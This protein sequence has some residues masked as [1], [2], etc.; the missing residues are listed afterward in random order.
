MVSNARLDLPEPESPVMTVR[1]SRGMSMLT[2][3]RF[4]SGAPRTLLWVSIGNTDVWEYGSDRLA[5]GSRLVIIVQG[6]S[7]SQHVGCD[8]ARHKGLPAVGGAVMT[9]RVGLGGM[10][11]RAAIS[12]VVLALL[13]SCA[14]PAP[15]QQ[16]DVMLRGGTIYDGSGGE[17]YI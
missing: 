13:T 12:I 9:W 11:M 16:A 17:P 15:Q 5:F 1:L 4:C 7:R 8:R 2:P 14:T 6:G 10:K 3:L